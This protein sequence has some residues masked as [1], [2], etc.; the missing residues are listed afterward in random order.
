MSMSDEEDPSQA[1]AAAMGFSSF[2]AKPHLNKKRKYNARSDALAS[3]APSATG[4]NATALGTRQPAPSNDNEI[5]LDEDDDEDGATQ[6][7]GTTTIQP[8]VSSLPQV[9]PHASLPARP[10]P[11]ASFNPQGGQNQHSHQGGGGG[12]GGGGGHHNNRPQRQDRA[13]WYEGYYDPM[14]NE[15]PWERL[16]KQNSLESKGTWI[17]RPDRTA[18][19]TP[20]S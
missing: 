11:Q 5:D 16:E 13:L 4:S 17:P 1:M 19:V 14:S 3:S 15:N 7:P 9:S 12:G 10:P 20:A 18:G 2:G 8:Q 6:A